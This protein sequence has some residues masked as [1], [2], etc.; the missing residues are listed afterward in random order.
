MNTNKPLLKFQAGTVVSAIWENEMQ[1]AGKSI[2]LLKATIERRYKDR[3]GTWKSSSSFS[4]HEIP[5]AIF[6]LQKAF[7]AIISKDT[8]R[9]DS[10][11]L[12]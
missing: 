2:K 9:E 10:E 4:R 7:E 11:V 1:A 5:I 8:V 3:Q 6:C 12:I